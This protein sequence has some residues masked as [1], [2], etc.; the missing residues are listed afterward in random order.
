MNAAE[1]PGRALI[2]QTVSQLEH[3]IFRGELKPGDKLSEQALSSRFGIS[4]GPLRE[5]IRSL[6]GRRLVER[7]PFAGVRVVQLTVDDIEQ[8]L[9]T[10]EALEGMACRQAAENMTL[11]ET[12]QLFQSL[13]ELERK[14]LEEGPSGVFR[15][16]AADND[17]HIQIA[18]GSRNRWLIDIICSELYP[19]LRICRFQ[20]MIVTASQKH[21]GKAVNREHRAIIEAIEQRDPDAAERL[22][23]AHL[24]ASRE[25]LMKWLRR[26]DGI[27]RTPPHRMEA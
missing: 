5:A 22:M 10:R 19:L 6:E 3:L 1:G 17:L 11:H 23:R 8:L 21:R 9:V 13:A 15:N 7:V 16:G 2:D 14:F 25:N 4:R 18:R 20:S 24:V 12:R 27:A 26:Q